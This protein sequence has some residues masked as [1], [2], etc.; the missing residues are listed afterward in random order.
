MEIINIKRILYLF[1]IMGNNNGMA[2]N[3]N[4]NINSTNI[5]QLIYVE[6]HMDS[7]NI[8]QLIDVEDSMHTEEDSIYTEESSE[9]ATAD[10]EESIES[11]E[12]IDTD[13]EEE[14]EEP[15]ETVINRDLEIRLDLMKIEINIFVS[16]E[17]IINDMVEIRLSNRGETNMWDISP[18]RLKLLSSAV[19]Y[20]EKLK[21]EINTYGDNIKKQRYNEL[22]EEVK[23]YD[24]Y[25]KIWLSFMNEIQRINDHMD[26]LA[27]KNQNIKD[28]MGNRNTHQDKEQK[29][30]TL[31]TAQSEAIQQLYKELDNLDAFSKKDLW[32]GDLPSNST[33]GGQNFFR[34]LIWNFRRSTVAAYILSR[35]TQNEL[36]RLIARDNFLQLESID[37]KDFLNFTETLKRIINYKKRP[38]LTKLDRLI[39]ETSKLEE[40]A[41][42]YTTLHTYK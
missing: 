33:P 19:A 21:E 3:N 20:A 5:N 16:A 9:F 13:R 35:N 42:D 32:N 14:P 15:F 38:F 30:T 40:T 12:S 31:L 37:Y 28:L 1:F 29:I 36:D 25:T 26:N 39:K 22:Y 41:K 4:T 11:I 8:N 2:M 10:T 17:Q 18:E 23:Y 24:N 6:D 7:I 27:N 34:T